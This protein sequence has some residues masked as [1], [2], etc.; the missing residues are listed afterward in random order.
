M[1]AYGDEM[2]PTIALALE[3]AAQKF[4]KERDLRLEERWYWLALFLIGAD[5]HF[6]SQI[7]SWTAPIGIIALE[8]IVLIALARKWGVDMVELIFLR[9]IDAYSK[10]PKD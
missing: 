2:S 3:E 7:Q 1:P 4:E 6:F 5:F 10:R 9:M 8:L